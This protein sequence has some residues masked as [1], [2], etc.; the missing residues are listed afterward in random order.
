MV[1]RFG[2]AYIEYAQTT[3]RFIPKV[4]RKKPTIERE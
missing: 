4:S 2:D 1:E 3:G